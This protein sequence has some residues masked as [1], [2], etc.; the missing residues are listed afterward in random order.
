MVSGEAPQAQVTPVARRTTL[1]IKA[2]AS[3][4]PALPAGER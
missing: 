3:P 2:L 1:M 4:S